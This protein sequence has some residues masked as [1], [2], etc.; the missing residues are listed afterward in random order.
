MLR[1]F[2]F[3]VAFYALTA[4]MAQAAEEAD[5][6]RRVDIATGVT[7]TA[8]RAPNRVN[9]EIPVQTIT[10]TAIRELGLPD[11]AAA[12]KHFAGANVKDYGGIGGMKTV[13]VRNMG[14]SHTA[15][16]Y[17]G[18]PVSNCQGGQIDIGRFS[19]DNVSTLSLAVG[20]AEDML[21]PA[22]LFGSGAVLMISTLRPEPPQGKKS[23]YMAE[24]KGGSW[25]YV[26]PSARWWQRL[27]SSTLLG[28]YASMMRSDGSYP[29]TLVNGKYVTR[30]KRYNSQVWSW[31][32]EA[33]LTHTFNQGGELAVKGYYYDS[34]RG[35]PG[36]VTLYNPISTETLRD[37]NAF[38]QASYTQQFN[39][40]WSMRAVAKY[41]YGYNRDSETGPQ[42]TDGYYFDIHRQHEYYLSGTAMWR[43]SEIFALSLAQDGILNTLRSTMADCPMPDRYTSLTAL[44]ARLTPGPVTATATL[45]A[46]VQREH[47][48]Q[49]EGPKDINRL[50]P[51][52]SVSYRPVESEMLFVRAL[53]KN[54]F[55]TPSFNDLYYSRLGNRS[56]NPERAHE[57]NAGVTWSKQLA[58]CVQYF[59]V[60][61]DGY[62][63]LV[64]D[65]IVAFPTTY[66]W[67]MA[68]YGKVR[69]GGIDATLATAITLPANMTLNV[70]GNYTWQRAIDVTDPTQK[71]YRHQLPYTPRHSG[72]A[73]ATLSTP[74][75]T[76]GYTLTAVGARYFMPQ[77]IDENRISGYAEHSLNLSRTQK[78]KGVELTANVEVLNLTNRQYD[79]VKYY[80]MPGRSWRAG[81]KITF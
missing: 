40:Q 30:E 4:M 13:S 75:A 22:K 61:L 38:V 2:I 3:I 71:I 7:V 29:F 48:R 6:A 25:G 44:T 70:S 67:R 59:T 66:V 28:V 55:R 73:L 60:T 81:L 16:A 35:I 9:T 5:T 31:H 15:V 46:T 45:L 41:N 12:V 69:A 1:N 68:N 56:L 33:N 8:Q 49:G 78:L 43:G 57:F 53:Y 65:K 51:S 10:S 74:W 19:I 42:F 37:R 39:E 54:T 77:N 20:Q 64:T 62:Y 27:G 52:L 50:N 24:V 34:Q 76:L 26:S 47:V 72:S 23:A 21:Q 17:D 58:S 18:V 80:P 14:A 63:N 32:T 36:A 11:V 79:I